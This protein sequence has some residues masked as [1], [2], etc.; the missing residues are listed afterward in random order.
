M[1]RLQRVA[2]V[3]SLIALMSA[4]APVLLPLEARAGDGRPVP[5]TVLPPSKIV[6]PAHNF[7]PSYPF[8]YNYTGQSSVFGPSYYAPRQVSPRWIPGYWGQQWMPLYSSYDVWRPGYYTH[9]GWI[10]GQYETQVVQSGGYY[11]PVW[12]NGYWAQ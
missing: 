9:G 1:S 7:G 4:L 11:Q 10:P 6:P 8:G 12:V 2:I 3:V 5:R